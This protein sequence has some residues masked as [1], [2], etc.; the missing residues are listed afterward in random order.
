MIDSVVGMIPAAPMPISARE[1]ISS[2]ELVHR[3]ARP[4]PS[5][6]SASPVMRAR[7]RP[8]RSPRL[9]AASR[10]PAKSSR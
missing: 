8:K 1:A 2:I 3:A 10:R 4:D 5:P 6:K 7:R 9:P